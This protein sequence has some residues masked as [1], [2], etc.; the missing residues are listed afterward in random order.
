MAG[1]GG[2]RGEPG[3]GTWGGSLGRR[4]WEGSLVAGHRGQEGPRT[5]TSQLADLGPGPGESVCNPDGEPRA[6]VL[7]QRLPGGVS[8]DIDFVLSVS[9]F[10]VCML[11]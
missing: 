8:A 7:L 9:R 2:W 11:N 10:P 3:E 6:P 5:Q 4:A 1:E